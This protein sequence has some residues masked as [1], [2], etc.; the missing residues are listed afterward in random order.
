[1]KATTEYSNQAFKL[2]KRLRIFCKQKEVQIE[3]HAIHQA[4]QW[5]E[6]FQSGN[7]NSEFQIF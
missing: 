4:T 7:K 3:T 2:I 5:H 6:N 1:M